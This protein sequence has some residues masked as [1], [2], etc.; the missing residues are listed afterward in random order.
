MVRR[1]E[2]GYYEVV[3]H[4]HFTALPAI[5]YALIS[6]SS[7]HHAAPKNWTIRTRSDLVDAVGRLL[8]MDRLR[9]LKATS[10]TVKPGQVSKPAFQ[11]PRKPD[12]VLSWNCPLRVDGRGEREACPVQEPACEAAKRR[13]AAATGS[14]NESNRP[15]AAVVRGSVGRRVGRHQTTAV[16]AGDE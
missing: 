8:A 5:G 9:G 4:G 15:P 11:Q 3:G 14:S 7:N 6:A 2:P 10:V 12:R 1:I 13:C 16:K